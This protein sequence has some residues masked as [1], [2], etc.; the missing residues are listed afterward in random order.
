MLVDAKAAKH[1][2]LFSTAAVT[3][4]VTT[5]VTMKRAD[6]TVTDVRIYSY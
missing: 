4:A 3:A 6:F 5:V 1:V 2:P